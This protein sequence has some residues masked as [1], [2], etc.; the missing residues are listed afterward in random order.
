MRI[1]FNP[2]LPSDFQKKST[3]A[4]N[5]KT[6]SWWQLTLKIHPRTCSCLIWAVCRNVESGESIQGGTCTTLNQESCS[7]TITFFVSTLTL[8][9]PSSWIKTIHLTCRHL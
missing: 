4:T 6:Q 7:R 1:Q 8:V 5:E 2:Y 9:Q 3:S